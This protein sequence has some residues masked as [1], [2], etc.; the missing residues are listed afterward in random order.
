MEDDDEEQGDGY[1]TGRTRRTTDTTGDFG[2]AQETA[3]P[4][5]QIPRKAAATATGCDKDPG[6]NGGGGSGGQRKAI[7]NRRGGSSAGDVKGRT[8]YAVRRYDPTSRPR[9][10]LIRPAGPRSLRYSRGAIS[11]SQEQGTM[12]HHSPRLRSH[13]RRLFVEDGTPDGRAAGV[14]GVDGG[15]GGGDGDCGGGRGGGSKNFY[16]HSEVALR[17]EQVG[18]VYGGRNHAKSSPSGSKVRND[19]HHCRR[20]P[21]GKVCC[22]KLFGI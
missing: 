7:T 9:V 1:S 8:P 17:S 18:F 5:K 12:P 14:G 10:Q 13:P 11:N 3:S 21:G 20:V 22:L 16:A 2:G 15:G 4:S 6:L 19:K